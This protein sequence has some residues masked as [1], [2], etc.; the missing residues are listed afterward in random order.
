[1]AFKKSFFRNF[2]SSTANGL[3]LA[4]TLAALTESLHALSEEEADLKT[5]NYGT[6]NFDTKANLAIWGLEN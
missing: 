2:L 4:G 3:A 6:I 1:M 5:K